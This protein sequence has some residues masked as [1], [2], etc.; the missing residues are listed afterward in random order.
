MKAAWLLFRQKVG[1]IMAYLVC[2][3]QKFGQSDLRG[4]SIHNNRESRNSKNKD[5]DYTRTER[6]FDA[7]S[8]EGGNP[9]T[10]YRA[11]V[12]KR[13]K[14]KYKGKRAIRK[15][16]VQL[17]SVL[18]S[19]DQQ[20]FKNLGDTEVHRFF[21]V[22]AEYLSE[23]FG[24]ENVVAAKVHM[25]ET[26]PHMHFT[27]VPLTDDGR[28]SAKTIIDR[29][30]LSSLQDELPKILQ[31]NGFQ[32]ERGVENSPCK[33]IPIPQLKSVTQPILDAVFERDAAVKKA[34]L[35]AK[36]E[37]A[38]LFDSSKVVKIPA[39]DYDTIYKASQGIKEIATEAIML[40]LHDARKVMP[41]MNDEIRE[42]KQQ[43]SDLQEQLQE[44]QKVIDEQQ[45]RL[46]ELEVHKKILERKEQWY[47]EIKQEIPQVKEMYA[48]KVD[49]YN[50]QLMKNWQPQNSRKLTPEDICKMEIKRQIVEEG[51]TFSAVD[52]SR[53]GEA[54]YAR[55][56][57]ISETEKVMKK[58][59]NNKNL[60]FVLP[61]KK[62]TER[63]H[64]RGGMEM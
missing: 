25:D 34:H 37:R 46:N 28:L 22:A 33:H 63:K 44:Q 40:Q 47:K 55:T 20:F 16:S 56:R 23:R 9:H 50:T 59:Y 29:K 1:V 32:I 19:S 15:D 45:R 30:A 41:R 6:N 39:K 10:N 64:E 60:K 4:V 52:K 36:V 12:E 13:L 48:E 18:V 11:E 7:L 35:N 8:G 57:S 5:I 27:F 53:V 24:R 26:T 49:Q 17:V 2:H 14:E 61:Q 31:H 42:Q 62:R 54:V 43:I 51:R 3:T 21:E 38:G 58:V